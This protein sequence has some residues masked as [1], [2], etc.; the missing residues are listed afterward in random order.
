MLCELVQD[1]AAKSWQ[2]CGPWG[3]GSLA[4]RLFLYRSIAVEIPN[5]VLGLF[6]TGAVM[7]FIGI[8]VLGLYIIESLIP[9]S[10]TSYAIRGIMQDHGPTP[11]STQT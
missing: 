11:G 10:W 9:L 4:K 5:I 6:S 3:A 2:C 1:R 8:F 7:L